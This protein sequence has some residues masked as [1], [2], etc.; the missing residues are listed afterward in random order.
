MTHPTIKHRTTRRLRF[1]VAAVT[2]LAVLPLVGFGSAA[3]ETEAVPAF[4]EPKTDNLQ[5]CV[6]F[7]EDGSEQAFAFDKYSQELE[8][9]AWALIDV[10]RTYG[11]ESAVAGV[12][13][14]SNYDGIAAFLPAGASHLK[15]SLA[16]VAAKH[17]PF[18]LHLFDVSRTTDEMLALMDKLD[19]DWLEAGIAG[20]APDFYTGGLV[21]TVLLD[22]GS[23]EK[24]V[25]AVTAVLGTDIPLRIAWGGIGEPSTRYVD[26][27]PHT[28]GAAICPSTAS[29]C[30]TG[31][32]GR[33]SM[34]VPVVVQSQKMMLTA[35]HCISS[36]YRNSG[37]TVGSTHTTTVSPSTTSHTSDRLGDWKLLK[38]A[39]YSLRVYN[40]FNGT[41]R[42][43]I[44]A[45]NWDLVSVGQGICVSGST[46]GQTCRYYV[47]TRNASSSWTHPAGNLGT[48]PVGRLTLMRHD[49]TGGSGFDANGWDHGDSGGPCYYAA[50]NGVTAMGIVTGRGWDQWN[51]RTYYCTQL[52]GLRA[53]APAAQLG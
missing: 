7:T 28:M 22:G 3:A 25:G 36:T 18:T 53:W 34:G 50:G 52:S 43:N 49:S 12:A 39:S 23:I 4:A 13:Y 5:P 15:E 21:V 19:F 9:M 26:P 10:I 24:A 16:A 51:R 48:Y 32:G 37:V 6:Q 47:M 40:D 41:S 1:V 20:L 27:A 11:G 29:T 31:T 44:T 2:S 45:A 30:N 35:G 17:Q 33:C 8:Q 38:G 42:L 14:C 46:T